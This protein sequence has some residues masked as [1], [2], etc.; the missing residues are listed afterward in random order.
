M[1]LDHYGKLRT[2]AYLPIDFCKFD[3][4]GDV[5]PY[6]ANDGFDCEYVPKVIYEGITGT[7]TNTAYKFEIPEVPGLVKER[8]TDNLLEIAKTCIIARNILHDQQEG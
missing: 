7:E 6:D 1:R 3:N 4:N 8:I 2:C 5:I